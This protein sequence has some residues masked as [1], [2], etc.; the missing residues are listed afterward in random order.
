MSEAKPCVGGGELYSVPACV[1]DAERLGD[2]GFEFLQIGARHRTADA[3]QIGGDFA[4]DVA[5]IE[6]VEA[7]MAE[8]FECVGELRL[9]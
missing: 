3:F 5:T 4:A 1:R 9:L 2:G 6:I 7:G 8:M